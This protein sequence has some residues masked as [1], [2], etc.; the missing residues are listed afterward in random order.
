M[1]GRNDRIAQRN[2]GR[3]PGAIVLEDLDLVVDCT[4]QRLVPRDPRSLTSEIE[5]AGAAAL[6]GI[7]T[8]AAC[9]FLIPGGEVAAQAALAVEAENAEPLAGAA[10]GCAVRRRFRV[11]THPGGARG[12]GGEAGLEIGILAEEDKRERFFGR[13]ELTGRVLTP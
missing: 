8:N 6:G 11:S 10:G 12:R 2:S 4:A 1:R 13:R 3:R 5:R 7:A 9:A